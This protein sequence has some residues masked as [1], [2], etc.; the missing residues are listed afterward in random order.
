MLHDIENHISSEM[1]DHL[2]TYEALLHKWQ[3]TINLVSQNSLKDSWERHILDSVQ[4]IE[5]LPEGI[6]T[7]YDLGSGAGFPGLIIAIL[8]PDLDVHLIESDQRKCSFLKTVSRETGACATVHAT[9]I[10][11]IELPSPD[12]VTARALA[13]LKQLLLY[14]DPWK[15][16]GLEG[17]FLKG[18]SYQGEIDEI[19]DKYNIE[20][21]SMK[22]QTSS[23][24]A[25]VKVK[26]L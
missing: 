17:L 9:R 20:C 15:R 5:H 22:S 14:C 12:V 7:L 2:K 16:K 13:P 25:L 3:K 24:A 21:S 23:S 11:S 19:P 10:E 1:Y 18:E 4:I 8:R 6:K 26:W